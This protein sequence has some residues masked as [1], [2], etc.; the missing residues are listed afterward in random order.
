[1]NKKS[2]VISVL[3]MSS[4]L[5]A[6]RVVHGPFRLISISVRSPIN[7][8]SVLG[9]S[10]TILLLLKS[11]TAESAC[12]TQ[13]RHRTVWLIAILILTAGILWQAL[14]FPLV[15]DEYTL[16]HYGKGLTGAMA[17][18]CLIQPGGDGFF[19][20]VGYLSL[21]LDGIWS[22][23]NPFQWHLLNVVLHLANIALVWWLAGRLLADQIAALWAAAMF[24]VHGTVLLTAI[25]LAARFDALSVFFVLAG[26]ALFVCYAE[27]HNT[28]VLVA[29][30]VMALLAVLTKE[31]A[32]SFPL[33]AVLVC[34]RKIKTHWRALAGYFLMA[35]AVFAYRYRLIGGIGG[36]PDA[37]T[38]TPTILQANWLGYLKGFGLRIW[39]VFYF[40]VNW[41]HKPELGL[42]LLMLAYIVALCLITV[43]SCG[44]RPKLILA[45]AFAGIALLPIA[46]LLLV[47]ATLLG[48]GRFYLALPGFAMF[49]GMAI[50]GAPK[51]ERVLFGSV[52][53]GFQLVALHHN[54]AIWG[55]TA[56]L[57]KRTC[58][59][60]AQFAETGADTIL[61]SG[62]PREIDG[63]P[64]LGVNNG[65]NAC[66]AF[67]ESA[68][69]H[70]AISSREFLWDREARQ[71]VPVK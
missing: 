50:R 70:K 4:A 61:V 7:L 33:L 32:F 26:L 34:G 48:A 1:M 5:L 22:D 15:F 57:A 42:A 19:R 46:H 54:L 21:G 18:Y 68:E 52:L 41:S 44:P 35:G 16:A 23:H 28:S 30:F 64:F 12:D 38:G 67:Y 40:P 58:S 37:A 24:A 10:S 62:L 13:P 69:Q 63:T 27:G 39:S 11:R 36:Y 20:P 17:K 2:V 47:D 59:V 60:A 31:V 66:V 14:S 45:L 3:V 43:R 9:L 56:S 6:L 55:K 8:Q 71:L 53:L 51:A 29:S 65:F 25:Y 49:L